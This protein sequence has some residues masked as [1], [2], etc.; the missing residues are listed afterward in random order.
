MSRSWRLLLFLSDFL[1]AIG[2]GEA[3]FGKVE[4]MSVLV[5]VHQAGGIAIQFGHRGGLLAFRGNFLNYAYDNGDAAD[6]NDHSQPSVG[7][8]QPVSRWIT[9]A[10]DFSFAQSNAPQMPCGE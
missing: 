6:Q 5:R 1:A 2:H 8:C 7:E 10:R 4:C 9:H 3:E